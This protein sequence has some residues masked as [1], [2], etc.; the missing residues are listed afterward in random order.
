MTERTEAALRARIDELMTAG[1]SADLEKLDRIYHDDLQILSLTID[2]DLMT[3]DKAGCLAMLEQTFKDETP[4]DHLWAKVHAVTVS[5][6]RGHVLIS[7][8]I[9]IGGPKMMFDLSIDLVFQDG[10]WQV[11]REV[12]FGRPDAEAA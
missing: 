7:R 2:G 10:R 6:D 1:V 5:G 4:E 8:K 12:N 11:I 9:P 3:L